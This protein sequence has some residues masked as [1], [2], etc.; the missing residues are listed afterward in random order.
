MLEGVHVS[1]ESIVEVA[2]TK[3]SVLTRETVMMEAALNDAHKELDRLR[4]L[5]PA[6]EE[7]TEDEEVVHDGPA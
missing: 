5:I 1:N 7:V 4:T 2:L 6:D 3:I